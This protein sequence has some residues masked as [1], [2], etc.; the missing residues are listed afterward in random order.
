MVMQLEKSLCNQPIAGAHHL[1]EWFTS[2][3]AASGLAVQRLS[4]CTPELS[5]LGPTGG[6][7]RRTNTHALGYPCRDEE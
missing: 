2:T 7:T 3:H 5:N 6:A 4:L 1:T